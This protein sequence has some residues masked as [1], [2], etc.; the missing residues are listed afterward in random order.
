MFIRLLLLSLIL[1]I[2]GQTPLIRPVREVSVKVTSP[3]QYGACRFAQNLKREVDF[4][5]NLRRLRVDNLRLAEEIWELESQLADCKELK[6]ENRLL[7]EQLEVSG[8]FAP[9]RLV[10]ARVIGRSA[11]GGESVLTINQG[12]EAGVCEGAA[13]IFKDFLLGEV[14]AAETKRA[15][16]RL[17]TDPQFSTT[18]L[19][20]DSPDR[21]R[22]LVRGQYGTTVVLKKI[23]PTESLVVGDT[24]ITSGEDGKFE[25]GLIL[26]KVKKI[27]GQEAGVFKEAELDLMINFGSLEEVFVIK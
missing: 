9:R 24:I 14:F 8:N 3:L 1:I 4:I 22:G 17:L 7:R 10:L 13:V 19:D 5:L 20:Q 15:K 11:R 21:A 23:L 16:V 12:L 18:A 6:Q 26:G 25:K 27:W 2:I